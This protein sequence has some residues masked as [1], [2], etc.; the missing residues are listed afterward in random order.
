M[1]A[2]VVPVGDSMG[3]NKRG[4]PK[5][6]TSMLNVATMWPGTDGDKCDDEGEKDGGKGMPSS[7]LVRREKSLESVRVILPTSMSSYSGRHDVSK[8]M[9]GDVR[10]VDV[11]MAVDPDC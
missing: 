6:E 9:S 5:C 1:D 7:V 11:E 10:P 4:D 2:V 3:V 8:L